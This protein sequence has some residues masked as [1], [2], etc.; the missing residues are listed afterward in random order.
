[1]VTGH[2]SLRLRGES[3]VTHEAASSTSPLPAPATLAF[4]AS[5]FVTSGPLHVLFP[6][7]ET[8]SPYTFTWLVRTGHSELSRVALYPIT[9]YLLA[10]LLLSP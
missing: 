8:F 6:Q 3:G 4:L 2:K 10:L 7:P 1:M 5:S 9:H